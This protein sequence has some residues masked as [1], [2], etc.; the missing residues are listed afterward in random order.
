MKS[1]ADW[2]TD[3]AAANKAVPASEKGPVTWELLEYAGDVT[4][5]ALGRPMAP[6]ICCGK[7]S[8]VHCEP[9]EFDLSYHY[10]GSTPRC[11]P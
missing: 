8:E 2:T 5:D 10:C 4:L 11:C 6:C 1:F 9:H 3:I 7:D